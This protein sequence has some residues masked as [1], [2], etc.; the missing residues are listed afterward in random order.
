MW[1]NGM[2]FSTGLGHGLWMFL[3]ILIIFA[4]IYFFVKIFSPGYENP[5]DNRDMTDSRDILK[6][7]LAKGEITEEEFQRIS[8]N[9]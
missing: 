7:R 9:L 4:V 3:C 6:Q 5:P 1:H 8:R 2:G